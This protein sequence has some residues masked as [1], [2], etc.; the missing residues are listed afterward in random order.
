MAAKQI[1][2]GVYVISLGKDEECIRHND[3]GPLSVRGWLCYLA[4]HAERE[5]KRA[6]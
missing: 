3:L 4:D 6:K 2:P 1:V 5:S